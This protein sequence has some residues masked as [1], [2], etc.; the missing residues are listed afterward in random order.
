MNEQNKQVLS[1]IIAAVESG[2]QVYSENNKRWTAYAGKYANTT[3]EVTCTLGC[4]QAYGDEAQE[5][6]QYIKD[7]YPDLDDHYIVFVEDTVENL[8]YVMNNSKFST[9]HITSFMK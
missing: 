7:N 4:Y 3:N 5:L 1:N 6:I 9:V 2:G 8:T